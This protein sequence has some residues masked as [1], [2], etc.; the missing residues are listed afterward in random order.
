MLLTLALP[1]LALAG[2]ALILFPAVHYFWDPQGLRKC[3][4]P[5]IAG[6]SSIWRMA[7]LSLEELLPD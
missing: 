2:L 1:L 5:S 7:Q 6:T 4:S 3:P